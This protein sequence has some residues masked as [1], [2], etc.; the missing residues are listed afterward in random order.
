MWVKCTVDICVHL[1]LWW[2]YEGKCN[3]TEIFHG[4]KW[5]HI[6]FDKL[7]SVFL[8]LLLVPNISMKW[9]LEEQQHTLCLKKLLN[10]SCT[11]THCLM[12]LF[13]Y[14]FTT[15]ACNAVFIL[16]CNRLGEVSI[17]G[18]S[19]FLT[20]VVRLC[21]YVLNVSYANTWT[22]LNK[23]EV[24]KLHIVISTSYVEYIEINKTSCATIL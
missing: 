5:T 17:Y 3:I 14:A 23:N 24:K 11:Q 21:G 2:I 22:T 6:F 13:I 15:Y 10:Y 20:P 1:Y 19:G 18:N 16:L 8:L 4:L 7:C 12:H 9:T